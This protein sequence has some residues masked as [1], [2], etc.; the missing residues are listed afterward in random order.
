MV[1]FVLV[2]LAL[3]GAVALL[4]MPHAFVGAQSRIRVVSS[5]SVVG[6][7]VERV[8]ADRVENVTLVG[9]NSDAHTFEPAP[10]DSNA[11]AQAA[12]VVQNG[13]GF[14]PWL[15]RL[16][17]SSR[18][19]GTRVPAAEGF[20]QLRLVDATD[21]HDTAG[22]YDPHVWHDVRAMMHMTIAVRDALIQLDPAGE[23]AYSANAQ[24]YLQ[25]L[26]VLDTWVIQELG[27]IPPERRKLVTS[28][29]TFGY[30]AQR[31]G[32][33]ILGTAL[34]S[35]STETADPSAGEIADL[36]R[37]IRASGAPAIFAEN[38]SNPRLMEQ[39]AAASNVELVADLY[40]DAL[41][42]PDS[43]GATYSGIVQHNISRIVSALSV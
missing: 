7:V 32:F 10:A 23:S 4:A 20:D 13:L 3:L 38:V 35:I 12:L 8:G 30:F 9:A 24:Q 21:A 37:E 16:Y 15:D 27:R 22:E 17:N 41:G 29:D 33:T 34:G 18:S 14:E 42:D 2:A 1:R 19:Q 5:F 31:Y 26:Q 39:I 43:A 25:D 28:H 6:E 11:L 36:I 40:T